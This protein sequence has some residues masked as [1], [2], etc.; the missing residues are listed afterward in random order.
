M[1]P[2][3]LFLICRNLFP[4]YPADILQKMVAYMAVLNE[5]T[6]VKRSF[7]REGAPWEFNPR[8]VI[9]W[10]TLLDRTDPP[11][12][13]SEYLSSVILQRFRT[14]DDRARACELFG[15]LF[16][17]ETHV[18]RPPAFASPTH[19]QVGHHHGQR[20]GR[21]SH[22]RS[23][24][25]LQAYLSAFESLGMCIENGWLAILTGPRN[26]GKTALVR[27]M[28]NLM[29][30]TLRE[31][32]INNATDA[33]D[34]LGSFEETDLGYCYSD[35]IREVVNLVDDMSSSDFGSRL[36]A[37]AGYLTMLHRQLVWKH[38]LLRRGL[39]TSASRLLPEDIFNAIAVE[40]GPEVISSPSTPAGDRA[41]LHLL[42]GQVVPIALSHL[43]RY[44]SHSDSSS[45]SHLRTLRT[46]L[47]TL[48]CS[49]LYRTIIQ[50]RRNFSQTSSIPP[51]AM[52]AQPLYAISALARHF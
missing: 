13:P 7:A 8:D 11:A 1:S 39:G 21:L 16:L 15:S 52:L 27:T 40:F 34:A 44:I 22:L 28:A 41:L 42:A 3:D 2:N 26:S 18:D 50:M 20:G 9:R 6:M 10:A 45:P 35:V 43:S 29:G 31:V 24:R 23:G 48:E 38:A 14:S 33:T 30:R 49:H 36:H 47:G 12:H 5:E 17:G 4:Q 46:Y 51:D 19:L 32:S 25:V 37:T